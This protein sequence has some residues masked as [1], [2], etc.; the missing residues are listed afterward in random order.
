MKKIREISGNPVFIIMLT[1]S[2]LFASCSEE[3]VVSNTIENISGKE[4]FK[5]IVFADGNLTANVPALQKINVT[6][7]LSKEQ[8][9]EFRS[10]QNKAIEYLESTDKNYFDNFKQNIMTRDVETISKTL[11]NSS[12]SLEPL[13]NILAKDQK[14]NIEEIKAQISNSNGENSDL[15]KGDEAACLLIVLI[16]LVWYW[17]IKD[18]PQGTS[19]L[20]SETSIINNTVSIQLVDYL[21]TN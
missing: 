6:E 11:S 13:V 16:L 21:T 3:A 10:F 19:A 2:F 5:S 1:F 18:I 17:Y 4:L 7:N 14:L 9:I 15:Q 12:K 8:L 20:D